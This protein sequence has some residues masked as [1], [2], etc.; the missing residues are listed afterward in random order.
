M[1][2]CLTFFPHILILGYLPDLFYEL[3]WYKAYGFLT[4]FHQILGIPGN[5]TGEGEG[6]DWN[7]WFPSNFYLNTSAL[8][9]FYTKSMHLITFEKSIQTKDV[10]KLW[11]SFPR[12]RG[13][14]PRLGK[15]RVDFMSTFN[16]SLSSTLV[17]SFKKLQG[18]HLL[19]YISSTV[20]VDGAKKISFIKI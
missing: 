7:L 3:I 8:I 16:C 2:W 10:W 6:I 15:E 12:K 13:E 5:M 9:C 4:I 11:M 17:S 1:Y 20:E 19:P 18:Q 14:E